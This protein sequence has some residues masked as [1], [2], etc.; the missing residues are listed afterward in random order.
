LRRL[1]LTLIA[2]FSLSAI[3][4]AAEPPAA[5]VA[6]SR[7]IL[8]E[9]PFNPNYQTGKG[10]YKNVDVNG[11]GKKDWIADF[12]HAQSSYYCGA[13]GC[14]LR[15]WVFEPSDQ[16]WRLEVERRH[17]GYELP[18][19]GAINIQVHGTYCGGSGSDSCRLDYIW[20]GASKTFIQA[21]GKDGAPT[22]IWP[23]R[24]VREDEPPSIVWAAQSAFS[25][26]CVSKGGTPDVENSLTSIPDLNGDG[27]RDWVFDGT[28]SYCAAK[29]GE[30]IMPPCDGGE[31][32][33]EAF[34][35]DPNAERG[36]RRV[37]RGEAFWRVAYRKNAPADLMILPYDADCGGPKQKPCVYRKAALKLE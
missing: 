21:P 25:T 19:P 20:D 13:G 10:F 28:A 36:A 2:A 32:A 16:S 37:Y 17:L 35:T 11:D 22:I 3:A 26:A 5:I 24:P 30:Q 29:G 4:R 27:V 9:D 1:F 7:A 31:C 34:I 33:V 14:P 12:M 6:D 23:P 8:S 18:R 15:A